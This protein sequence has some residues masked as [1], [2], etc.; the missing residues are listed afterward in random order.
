M[1]A[2]TSAPTARMAALA[3]AALVAVAVGTYAAARPPAPLAPAPPPV[4][5]AWE[6]VDLGRF[7]RELLLDAATLQREG[8]AIRAVLVLDPSAGDPR[9]L[10]VDVERRKD[11]L[12]DAVYKHVLDPKSDGELRRPGALERLREEI[13]ARVNRELGPGRDGHE[14]VGRVLFPDRSLPPRR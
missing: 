7:E 13:K 8:F 4:E 9:G 11:A 3:V 12:R 10:R 14:I 5:E 2:S 1:A 6:E